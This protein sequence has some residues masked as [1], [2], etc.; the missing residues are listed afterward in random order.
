[1]EGCDYALVLSAS[2][3]DS[4]DSPSLCSSPA[5]RM[6]ANGTTRQ[7]SASGSKLTCKIEPGDDF[8]AITDISRS[9]GAL[10]LPRTFRKRCCRGELNGENNFLRIYRSC[11]SA[12]IG[13]LKK[14]HPALPSSRSMRGGCL[15][16]GLTLFLFA[17]WPWPH[18]CVLL[19]PAF[20][21]P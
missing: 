3:K 19:W 18:H 12:A 9:S 20:A 1:M 6:F 14:V 21:P 5:W 4:S 17:A 2:M 7:I 13:M 11:Y 16:A 10:W 15:S 8:S